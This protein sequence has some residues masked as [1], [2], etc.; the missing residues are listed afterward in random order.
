VALAGE[1]RKRAEEQRAV[2][3]VVVRGE[4]VGQDTRGAGTVDVSAVG[5]GLAAGSGGAVRGD[6]TETCSDS[7]A[8]RRG[9]SLEVLLELGRRAGGCG[10]G[11]GSGQSVAVAQSG[12]DR[13]E[14]SASAVTLDGSTLREGLHSSLN[15]R[16]LYRVDIN[17]KLVAGVG[18]DS[19]RESGRVCLSVLNEPLG[20]DV[21]LAAGG[22]VVELRKL[23]LNLDGLAG[24]D[25][26]EG[27][28]GKRASSHALEYTKETGF[29]SWELSVT[30]K[31]TS[32]VRQY[33][34]AELTESL[35]V[36][37]SSKKV[38]L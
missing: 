7:A 38:P 6:G 26:L 25:R 2:G 34:P 31:Q 23:D 8:S 36:G 13:T 17:F 32:R 3:D 4:G 33:L 19:T 12:A 27:L 18:K 30:I 28:L 22:E 11:S 15:L 16:S 35:S 29:G 9:G 10:S 5:A 20:K 21:V 24:R 1:G 14:A 37:A